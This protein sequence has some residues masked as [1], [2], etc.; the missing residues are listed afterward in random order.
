MTDQELSTL[1]REWKSTPAP[2]TLEDRVFVTRR[3]WWDYIPGTPVAAFGALAGVLIVWSL[4]TLAPREQPKLQAPPASIPIP[5]PASKNIEPPAAMVKAPS[6]RAT[7]KSPTPQPK[8]AQ[9][10]SAPVERAQVSPDQPRVL[11]KANPNF[12]SDMPPA[13]FTT[14]FKVRIRVDADGKVQE[15][16][17]LTG[18]PALRDLAVQAVMQG[19]FSP[20]I[21]NGTPVGAYYEIEV[22]FQPRPARQ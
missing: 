11:L 5:V 22:S 20:K 4:S 3:P 10:A 6:L 2:R 16:T 8:A 21:T 9:P 17:A 7:A 14:T 15:A 12:P 13:F 19:L 1:L 18:D